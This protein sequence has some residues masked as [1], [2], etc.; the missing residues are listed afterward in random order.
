MKIYPHGK[1]GL[2]NG[3][4]RSQKE[5]RLLRAENLKTVQQ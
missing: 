2:Q 5:K 4:M 1:S 3:G